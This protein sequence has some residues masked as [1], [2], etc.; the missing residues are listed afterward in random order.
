MLLSQ[1][2]PGDAPPNIEILKLKWEKQMRLPQNFDPSAG[3]TGTINDPT[4]SSS[5]AASGGGRADATTQGMQPAGPSRVSFVYVYSMKIRNTGSKAIE[6]VAWDYVFLDPSN[7]TEAGRHQFLS[8]EKVEPSKSSTYQAQQRFPPVRTAH[9]PS[10]KSDGENKFLEK[11]I[12]QCVLYA[13]GTTWR[14]ANAAESV[15]D[16]LK[17]GKSGL[18]RKPS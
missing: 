16:L 17:K 2:T 12:I 4:R 18:A 9:S 1:T 14:N 15:C 7:S 5:G 6:G 13:D 11:S 10:T 3:S 8:F